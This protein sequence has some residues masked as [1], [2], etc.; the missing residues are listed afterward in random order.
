VRLF[1]SRVKDL[2]ED[3]NELSIDG[4]GDGDGDTEK[5]LKNR[6]EIWM[7]KISPV[8]PAPKKRSVFT[9]NNFWEQY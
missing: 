3:G 8:A 1:Q 6:E 2:D 7:R 9:V 4:D 5:Y